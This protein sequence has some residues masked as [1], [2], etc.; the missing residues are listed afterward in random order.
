MF[1]AQADV[2]FGVGPGGAKKFVPEGCGDRELCLKDGAS[3]GSLGCGDEGV[4]ERRGREGEEHFLVEEAIGGAAE[5][6]WSGTGKASS[7]SAR[8]SA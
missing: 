5:K 2:S 7:A 8:G 4:D 1:V 6:V 3:A